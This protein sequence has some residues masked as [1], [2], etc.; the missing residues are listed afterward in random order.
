[1]ARHCSYC[2]GRGHNRATC[3]EK[4]QRIK[5]NPDSYLARQEKDK[6]ARRARRG[7]STRQCGYCEETGHNKRTCPKLGK[8]RAMTTRD[9]KKFTKDFVAV[10][11]KLGFGPGTLMQVALPENL[12]GYTRSTAESMHAKGNTLAMVIG[13]GEK[14]LNSDL[15]KADQ[16]LGY[17]DN[18]VRVRFPSGRQTMTPLP[19]EF[20]LL[21]QGSEN[22]ANGM[23]QIGCPVD[24]SG[25]HKSLTAEWHTG[26]KSVDYQLGLEE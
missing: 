16:Y 1:M 7:P 18:V 14:N 20:A 17:K 23:W 2:Y 11:K 25:M 24:A 15:T 21:V 8:D 26:E 19:K 3:P 9:N 22:T 13:W 12:S 5:D 4:R 6:K 10:C